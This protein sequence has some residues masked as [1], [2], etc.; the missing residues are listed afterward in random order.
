MTATTLLI[1]STSWSFKTCILLQRKAIKTEKGLLPFTSTLVILFWSSVASG[2]RILAI[3]VLF[4]PSLGLFNILNHW[5]A[6]QIPFSVRLEAVEDNNMTSGDII[7]LNGMTRSVNW[8]TIDRWEYNQT[9]LEAHQPP[10]Y[11]L[12]TGLALGQTFVTFLILMALHLVAITLVKI[13]TIK[14]I[15]KGNWIDKKK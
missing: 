14:N 7:Q 1:L 8:T 15:K 5:K 2:R 3:I 12:Y 11:S 4:L 10:H 9:D 6:E 13:K